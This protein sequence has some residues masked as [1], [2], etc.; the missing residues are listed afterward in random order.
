MPIRR[1]LFI[2]YII[3]KNVPDAGIN[4]GF[5]CIPSGIATDHATAPGKNKGGRAL[6]PF[7][8]PLQKQKYESYRATISSIKCFIS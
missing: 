1:C 7:F 5:S 3:R 8:G 6:S 4:L 2:D